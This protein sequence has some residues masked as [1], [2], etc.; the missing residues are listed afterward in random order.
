MRILIV[1][2][3][4]CN[5]CI[6]GPRRFR[7]SI[8][9]VGAG[10]AGV[11][12]A[13]LL[14][15]KGFKDV[16][17]LERRSRPGGKSYTI[18]YR[19]APHDMGTVYL[20]PDYEENIIQLMKKFTGDHLAHLPSASIW[21]DKFKSPL[22]YQTYVGLESLKNFQT[23][24]KTLAKLK[25]F[26]SIMQYIK[27]H[28]RLFG[29]Y[30]GELMPRPNQYVMNQIRG[31]FMEFLKRNNLAALHPLFLASHTMQGY[32]HVDEISALYGLMWNTPKLMG[33]LLS[34]MK[35]VKD[36]GMLLH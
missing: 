20:S 26:N 25:L 10:P 7:D 29:N 31:T 16:T 14:K 15:K 13:Y 35:G 28:Q 18:D 4:P 23:R 30:T 27:L 2:F 33:G 12:M 34:R 24:N 32:G 22:T 21:L 1:D 36:T 19:G 3:R 5:G 11:H 8:A 17:L 9:I 6:R